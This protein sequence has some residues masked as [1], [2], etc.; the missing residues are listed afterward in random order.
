MNDI[1]AEAVPILILQR[2]F[3]NET[4]N[5]GWHDYVYG[6]GQIHGDYW[7]GLNRIYYLTSTGIIL[8]NYHII[9]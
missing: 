6:F 8:F 4:F 9:Y 7:A 2:A 1:K 3:G 5:R